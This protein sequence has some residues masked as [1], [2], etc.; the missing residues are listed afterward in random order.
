M[1]ILAFSLREFIS[2]FLLH[3]CEARSN[4][5]TA[6][7]SVEYAWEKREDRDE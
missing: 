1:K 6:S 7:P 4:T 5:T 3:H 2:D